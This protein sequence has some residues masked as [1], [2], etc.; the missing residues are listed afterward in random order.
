MFVECAVSVR[1]VSS[2]A[3]LKYVQIPFHFTV[4]SP[5]SCLSGAAPAR[6]VTE[7]ALP[8]NHALLQSLSHQ[9]L[10]V[11]STGVEM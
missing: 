8:Q 1:A 5:E 9:V 6:G 11:S 2:C 3:R 10:L 4:G 7:S